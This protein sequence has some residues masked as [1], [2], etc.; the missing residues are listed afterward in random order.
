M[1]TGL[2]WLALEVKYLDP[3]V[4]LYRDHLDLAVRRDA[5][6][7]VVLGAG[8][9]DLVLRRPSGVPR[10]G[11]H[12]HYA[13]STPADA[14][15]D[16]WDRLSATFDLHEE[17]FG[18][19]RSL[20][21]YDPE[22]NCVEIG[23]RD[24]AGEG[25]TGI[26]E[27]VLE[28]TDLDRALAFYEALG[29]EDPVDGGRIPAQLKAIAGVDEDEETADVAD[30]ANDRAG[31]LATDNSRDQ[32][33]A[34]VK[35]VRDGPDDCNLQGAGVTDMAEWLAEQD[36]AAVHEALEAADEGGDD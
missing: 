27:V 15:D 5:D 36:E 8:D 30:E 6:D 3:V 28:V 34:A 29:L 11:L 24:D 12:T 19:M 25:I 22:G 33:K 4:D 32:L 18:S 16:W 31:T 20:Y 13:F 10:G 23:G 17:T 9:T 21:F 7:E 35:E 1:L 14:Y 2:R 26:F